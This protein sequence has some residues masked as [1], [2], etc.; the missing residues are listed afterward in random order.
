[1]EFQAIT[2]KRSRKIDANNVQVTIDGFRLDKISLPMAQGLISCERGI[3]I[4]LG[5]GHNT[6]IF[7]SDNMLHMLINPKLVAYLYQKNILKPDVD[8]LY[9]IGACDWSGKCILSEVFFGIDDRSH[10]EDMLIIFKIMSTI[11]GNIDSKQLSAP[12]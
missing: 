8:N 4:S 9:V 11:S 1:M 6:K 10:T 5:V 2:M 12:V 7:V 3:K